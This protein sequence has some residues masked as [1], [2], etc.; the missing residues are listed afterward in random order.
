VCKPRKLTPEQETEIL[1]L[2]R[3]RRTLTNPALA[4]RFGVSRHLI[5]T[6]ANDRRQAIKIRACLR[7]T[8]T[9]VNTGD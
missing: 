3:L 1:T 4:K 7:S 2:V 6:I 8:S 5:D 9:A